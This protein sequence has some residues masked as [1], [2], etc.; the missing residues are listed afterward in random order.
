MYR[1][2]SYARR[3]VLLRQAVYET[4]TGGEPTVCWWGL[5][6]IHSPLH[7]CLAHCAIV[8]WHVVRLVLAL[9]KRKGQAS[10]FVDGP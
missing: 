9:D 10:E 7:L 5:L 2:A 1:G 4:E 3:Y 6:F 8:I